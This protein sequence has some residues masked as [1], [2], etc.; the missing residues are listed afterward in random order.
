MSKAKGGSQSGV[1]LGQATEEA[2]TGAPSVWDALTRALSP[3]EYRR[4]HK[5]LALP[6]DRRPGPA[7]A[8]S[9]IPHGSSPLNA[10]ESHC[11]S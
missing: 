5:V 1:A 4:R 10:Y 11:D 6:Q 8:V 7:A 2:K 3:I 9:P